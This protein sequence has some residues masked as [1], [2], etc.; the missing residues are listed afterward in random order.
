M[1]SYLQVVAIITCA[2]LALLA[3]LRRKP[4]RLPPGPRGWPIFGNSFNV[5]KQ[6]PWITYSNWSKEYGELDLHLDDLV[7]LTNSRCCRVGY[8]FPQSQRHALCRTQ[9]SAGRE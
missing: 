8:N 9:L 3:L 4:R 1:A 6:H 2:V 5:P 7:I